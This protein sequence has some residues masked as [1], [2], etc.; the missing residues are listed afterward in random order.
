VSGVVRRDLGGR[1]V[2]HGHG[3]LAAADDLIGHGYTLLTGH[4]ALVME[5]RLAARAAS[6]IVVPHGLVEEVAGDLR[7]AV[8]GRRLV[9]FGGGHVI[10]V[11]KALVAADPPRTLVAIP[12]TLSGAEMTRLHRHARGVAQSMPRARANVV[13]NDPELSASAPAD[14]LAAGSANATGHALTALYADDATADIRATASAALRLTAGAWA[15]D[16]PDRSALALAAMLAGD[17]VGRT[18]LGL[19]HVLAQSL[20]RTLGVAHARANAIV[21]PP[22][23]AAL[24]ARRPAV[25]AALEEATGVDPLTLARVLHARAHVDADALHAAG[26]HRMAALVRAA[27]ERPETGRTSPA[28]DRTEIEA[29]YLEAAAL[30][31]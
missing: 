25:L 26:P 28:P 31:G 2:V 3:A 21:L 11:A 10:D 23:A 6:V 15:R 20:V 12:T 16:E 27:L 29:L 14:L 30:I 5:P 9:A 7:S 18:G 22:S 13:V 1:I 4:R 24:A 8:A 19:H 17:A